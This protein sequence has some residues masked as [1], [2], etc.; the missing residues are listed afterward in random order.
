MRLLQV[1]RFEEPDTKLEGCGE[2]YILLSTT[3][4]LSCGQV[5]ENLAWLLKSSGVKIV[6]VMTGGGSCGPGAQYNPIKKE[7]DWGPDVNRLG[8]RDFAAAQKVFSEPAPKNFEEVW[9]RYKA[10]FSFKDKS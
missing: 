5:G 1:R 7:S 4:C 3:T 9:L 8:I 10:T 6:V 2:D